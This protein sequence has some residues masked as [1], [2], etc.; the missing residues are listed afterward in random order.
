MLGTVL[1]STTRIGTWAFW[2]DELSMSFIAFDPLV[3]IA[4]KK[5]GR[6]LCLVVSNSTL[7]G[8]RLA[9]HFGDGVLSS[10]IITMMWCSSAVSMVLLLLMPIPKK[11]DPVYTPSLGPLMS[12]LR[13]STSL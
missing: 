1:F 8:L 9:T 7:M 11:L 13:E 5:L 4:T 12:L 3:R 10:V 2:G 6:L